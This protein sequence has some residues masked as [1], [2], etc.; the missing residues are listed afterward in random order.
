M[1]LYILSIPPYT[2]N[3]TDVHV[4][5]IE[6]QRYTMSNIGEL[7]KRIS[8]LEYYS[9]LSSFIYFTYDAFYLPISGPNIC[10]LQAPHS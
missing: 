1:T 6:N 8:N 3:A 10:H 7:D 9:T 5:Y 2:Y 4:Q